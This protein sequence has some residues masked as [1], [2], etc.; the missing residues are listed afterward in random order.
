MAGR[1]LYLAPNPSKCLKMGGNS[2]ELVFSP[3]RS[4]FEKREYADLESLRLLSNNLDRLRLNRSK[5]LVAA[6]RAIGDGLKDGG[7]DSEHEK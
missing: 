5:D 4:T 6:A 1:I 3:W 2:D 7:L